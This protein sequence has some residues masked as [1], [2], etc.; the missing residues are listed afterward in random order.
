MN[1][2]RDGAPD[3]APNQDLAAVHRGLIALVERLGRQMDDC[4]TASQVDAIATQIQQA[5]AR[6]T[7]VGSVL[8]AAQTSDIARLAST[9]TAAFPDLERAIA[10]RERTEAAVASFTSLLR[11]VDETVNVARMVC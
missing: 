8:L 4:T 2:P 6:V 7:A 1:N 10:D 9:V 5:T 11:L 3:T